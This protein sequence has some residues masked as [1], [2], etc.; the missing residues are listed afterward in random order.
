MAGYSVSLA[1]LGLRACRGNLNEACVYLQ[2]KEEEK[3]ERKRKDKEEEGRIAKRKKL[4]RT[5]NG[6]W[7]NLG[8]LETIVDMGFPR[9]RAVQ[10]LKTTNNDISRAV[11]VLQEEMESGADEA[12]SFDEAELAQVNTITSYLHPARLSYHSDY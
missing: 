9:S 3:R 8:Y 2:H 7:L 5:S 10:S 11:Q 1:R 6:E 4:G 12:G